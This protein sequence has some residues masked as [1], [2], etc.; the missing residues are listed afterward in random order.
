MPWPYAACL[1]FLEKCH[2]MYH[3][4]NSAME[5]VHSRLNTKCLVIVNKRVELQ[6]GPNGIHEEL[7]LTAIYGEDRE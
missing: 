4:K 3:M 5:P 2:H 7:G 1:L 6:H